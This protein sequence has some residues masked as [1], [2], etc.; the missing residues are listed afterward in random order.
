MAPSDSRSVNRC[1]H[2]HL[3]CKFPIN[4]TIPSVGLLVK[5]M[6][7][8]FQRSRTPPDQ[9]SI[10]RF[11]AFNIRTTPELDGKV[12]WVSPDITEEERTGTSYYTLR[13]AVSNAEL[14]KL[15]GLKVIPGMP[16]EAFIQTGARSALSY[17]LKPLADQIEHSPGAL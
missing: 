6:S 10:L 15:K 17:F 8:F 7:F 2:G 16:V 12:S 14:A 1:G 4:V 9:P 5:G 11:S 13:I 3:A